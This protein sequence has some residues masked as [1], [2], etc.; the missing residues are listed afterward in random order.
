[1]LDEGR[2]EKGTPCV[3]SIVS[4]SDSVVGRFS[5]PRKAKPST[6]PVGN[7][8]S[9]HGFGKIHLEKHTYSHRTLGWRKRLENIQFFFQKLIRI[10]RRRQGKTLTNTGGKLRHVFSIL[11]RTKMWTHGKPKCGSRKEGRKARDFCLHDS[12]NYIEIGSLA[13]SAT[14]KPSYL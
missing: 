9:W 5:R 7:C 3:P 11:F 14:Q 6:M 8:G 1:M 13:T 4:A 12:E 2:Y 10:F